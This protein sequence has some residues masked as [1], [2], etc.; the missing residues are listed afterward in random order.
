MN[1]CL[2]L[3]KQ[4]LVFTCLQYKSF[5]NTVGKGA[6]SPFPTEF[7]TFLENFLSIS[8]NLKLYKT[9]S[10]WK[11]L[12]F[13]VWEKVKMVLDCTQINESTIFDTVTLAMTQND[14][15]TYWTKFFVTFLQFR[16]L[17]SL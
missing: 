1:I 10:I 17:F 2:T 5:E 8:S 4:A 16:S 15:G 9:L 7:S 13:V 11:S 12:Q 6:I 14:L 3:S